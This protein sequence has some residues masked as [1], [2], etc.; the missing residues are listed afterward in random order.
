MRYAGPIPQWDDADEEADE[1]QLYRYQ[2]ARK[3]GMTIVE[4]Q[5]FRDSDVTLSQLRRLVELGCSGDMLAA[6]LL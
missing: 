5:L 4:A 2:A 6:I 3:A 1:F